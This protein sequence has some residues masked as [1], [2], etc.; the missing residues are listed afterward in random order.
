MFIRLE[1]TYTRSDGR[2]DGEKW[3]ISIARQQK[4]L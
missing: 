4:K 1:Q 2:T 3:Y